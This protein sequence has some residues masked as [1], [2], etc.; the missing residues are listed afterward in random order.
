MEIKKGRLKDGP[1]V[2]RRLP[3]LL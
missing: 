3:F 1:V 2:R